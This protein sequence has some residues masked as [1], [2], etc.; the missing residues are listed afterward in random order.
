MIATNR[1][2]LVIVAGPNGAGKTTLTERVLTHHWV[3]G[4]AYINPDNIAR[5]LFGDWNS[6][7]AVLKAANYAQI[8][9]E[10]CLL[11]RQS[12]IFESV[13]SGQDKIDFIRRAKEAGY[14]IRLFFV[15]TDGP[16]INAARVAERVASGGHAVPIDKIISRY[17]KSIANCA[18]AASI[19]DRSYVYDNSVDDHEPRLLFRSVDGK[20]AKTYGIINEWAELIV[21]A[22]KKQLITDEEVDNTPS[23][24]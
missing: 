7:E 13:M 10:R 17:S 6:N 11:E 22:L 3:S 20:I 5:D 8:E 9:R 4:C 18:I 1:P 21:K 15:G 23:P 19:S 2:V 14:F 12:M 24:Q 16:S